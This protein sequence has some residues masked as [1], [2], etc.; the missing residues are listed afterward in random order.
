MPLVI[1]AINFSHE[2]VKEK[3]EGNPEF[4]NTIE[5]NWDE[6]SAV[7]WI[8]KPN[9]DKGHKNYLLLTKVHIPF[10]GDKLYVS[11][12]TVEEMEQYRYVMG[13][14]CLECEDK[15]VSRY[16]HDFASCM[17]GKN[18][19]DGGNKGYRRMVGDSF[20]NIYVDLIKAVEISEEEYNKHKGNAE[21]KEPSSDRS[22]SGVDSIPSRCLAII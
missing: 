11:G 2:K 10:E 13:I 17:C 14:Q 1:N 19:V 20:R 9:L 22:T 18:S 4:I 7:Y 21:P 6:P 3:F 5:C 12:M 16:R 15:V 8:E